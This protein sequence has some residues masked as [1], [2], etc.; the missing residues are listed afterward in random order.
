MDDVPTCGNGL[1]A[2]AVL[3]ATLGDVVSALGRVLEVH[4]TTL[5]LQD[6]NSRREHAAYSQLVDM[7][8]D[9]AGALRAAAEHMRGCRDLPMGRHDMQAMMAPE[10]V[11]AFARFVNAEQELLALLQARLPGDQAMLADMK[12]ALATRG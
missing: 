1:A 5:D 6:E 9:I 2:N 12:E 4:L 3:P 10:P 8:A 11:E 7:D